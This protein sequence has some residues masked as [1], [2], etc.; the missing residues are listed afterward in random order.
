[1]A[2]GDDIAP[3]ERIIA[4]TASAAAAALVGL[5]LISG[6][7]NAP[8]PPESPSITAISIANPVPTPPPPPPAPKPAASPER[9]GA[10]A[11][12]APRATPR[13][14]IARPSPIPSPRR[15]PV[16]ADRGPDNSAGAA[17]VDGPGTGAGGQGQG[18]GSGGAG[19]GTGGGGGGTPAAYVSG[20][21]RNRDYPRNASR[22]NQGGTVDVRLTVAP[23]GRV[24][25]CSVMRSSGNPDLDATTCR[26]IIERFRYRPAR[27]AAG[28]PVEAVMGWRQRWWLEDG[29]PRNPA[30]PTAAPAAP[31]PTLP[32]TPP[33]PPDAPAPEPGRV[34]QSR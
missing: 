32:P 1:M 24:T 29:G 31:S 33:A 30:P 4:A 11:P 34:N 2:Y 6:W 5:A 27:N 16:V 15:A 12:P 13:E 23:S 26:L 22:A 20:R 21:I 19:D 17:P 8:P 18:R 14:V 25:A 3:R 9:E 7:Q 10:A 28:E